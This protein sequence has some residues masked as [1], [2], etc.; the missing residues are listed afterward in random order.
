MAD[1]K[2]RFMAS[3]GRA[4][5]ARLPDG[6]TYCLVIQTPDEDDLRLVSNMDEVAL[7]EALR[8]MAGGIDREM[9]ERN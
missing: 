2:T 8:H 6:S 7:S 4:V 5:R 9:A 3:L 1:D